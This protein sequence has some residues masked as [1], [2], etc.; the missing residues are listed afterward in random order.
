MSSGRRD[1]CVHF[2]VDGHSSSFQFKEI[3][4]R[5]ER[6]WACL[7][8]PVC[9]DFCWSGIPGGHREEV[10][11]FPVAHMRFPKGLNHSFPPGGGVFSLFLILIGLPVIVS[12][13]FQ[14]LAPG[15]FTGNSPKENVFPRSLGSCP[16]S[17]LN[18]CRKMRLKGRWDPVPSC[19]RVLLGSPSPLG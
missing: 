14:R 18:S 2:T 17:F 7:L 4:V 10:C 16:Q 11:S 15:L 9:C 19:L 13:S 1:R 12:P 8:V 6:S 3:V 5:G